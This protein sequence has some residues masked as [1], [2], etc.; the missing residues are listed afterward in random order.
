V[1]PFPRPSTVIAI[2]ALV[3]ASSGGA[4]AA[5]RLI[6]GASIKNASIAGAKLK[7]HAVSGLQIDM[8]RL[9]TVPRAVAAGSAPLPATLPHR[10]SLTGRYAVEGTGHVNQTAVSF[11]IPLASARVAHFIAPRAASPSQCPGTLQR[12]RAL[13]GNLCVDAF[14]LAPGATLQVFDPLSAGALA[15]RLGFGIALYQPVANVGTYVF[16]SGTWAVDA[17]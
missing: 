14:D 4:F 15:N 10:Q 16:S 7:P 17:S 1:P 11:L 12:P 5:G 9:G 3:I 13:P 8:S 2:A 6:D